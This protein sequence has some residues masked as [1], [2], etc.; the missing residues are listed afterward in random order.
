M[1]ARN[2]GQSDDFF[3]DIVHENAHADWF[4]DAKES[5]KF[6]IANNLRIPK[7]EID[8]SVDFKFS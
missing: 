8:V 1:M 4:L 2:C 3:K 7:L 6:K 5:K